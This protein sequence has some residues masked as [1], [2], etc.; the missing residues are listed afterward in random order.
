MIAVDAHSD[1][2]RHLIRILVFIDN[3]RMM[4]DVVGMLRSN[5]YAEIATARDPEELGLA[6]RQSPVDLLLSVSRTDQVF[7]GHFV[8][9]IRH[10][11]L[12]CH[13]FPVVFMLLPTA[14]ESHVKAVID[15]GVDDLLVS[16][17][18]GDIL[19][20]RLGAFIVERRPFTVTHAYIGPNRRLRPREG[21]EPAPLVHVPN[22]VRARAL[23][24]DELS[25][26]VA[27]HEASIA[28]NRLKIQRDGY[29]VAWL[30]Q[31]LIVALRAPVQDLALINDIVN[32]MAVAANEIARRSS[33]RSTQN[34]RDQARRVIEA[35]RAMVFVG[36]VVAPPR[37]RA[38]VLASRQLATQI[39]ADF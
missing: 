18:D 14:E 22:P 36:E 34:L 21:S 15:S 12:E 8:H 32:R 4:S 5:G 10:A 27:L 37:A 29:Q 17:I 9:D 7:I 38:L 16:P 11:R 23:G 24:Q 30:L 31:K 2:L 26:H 35:T 20:K 13:P 33:D 28:L 25:V 3:D 19:A 1:A 39:A 6:L